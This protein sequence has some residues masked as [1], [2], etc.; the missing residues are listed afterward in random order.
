MNSLPVAHKIRFVLLFGSLMFYV[1][2]VL[3]VLKQQAILK[4][5]GLIAFFDKDKEAHRAIEEADEFV[6][7]VKEYL[8]TG[9][10]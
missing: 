3:T 9:G 2:L 1:A 6:A 4:H 5:S 7:Q 8:T 10:D